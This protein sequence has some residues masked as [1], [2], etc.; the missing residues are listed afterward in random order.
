MLLD[1]EYKFTAGSSKP[2]R[3]N[4]YDISDLATL[5]YKFGTSFGTWFLAMQN[6]VSSSLLISQELTKFMQGKFINMD[7]MIYDETKDMSAKA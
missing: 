7:W 6:F 2:V 3:D 4:S 5:A 1:Q